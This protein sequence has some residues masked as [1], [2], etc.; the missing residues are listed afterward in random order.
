MA[1]ENVVFQNH[2]FANKRVAGNFAAVSD[3]RA[4]LDFDKSPDFHVVADFTTVE[5]CEFVDADVF[6]QLHVGRNPLIQLG[7]MDHGSVRFTSIFTRI[8]RLSGPECCLPFNSGSDIFGSVILA[9][10]TCGSAAADLCD[11]EDEPF[12]LLE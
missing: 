7:R 8:F 11:G 1:D 5:M 2:A 3:F 4:F 12:P 9:D 10:G 6:A